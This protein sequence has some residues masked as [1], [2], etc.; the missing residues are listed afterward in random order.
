MESNLPTAV[1]NQAH[2][3]VAQ[4]LPD[5]DVCSAKWAVIGKVVDC[6]VRT[7]LDCGYA[8]GFGYGFLCC[9]PESPKIVEK[10]ELTRHARH[11]LGQ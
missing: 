7:P 5:P 1:R 10:T 9:H 6:L 3:T 11:P 8:S 2:S 4:T